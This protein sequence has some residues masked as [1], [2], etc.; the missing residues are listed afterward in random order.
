MSFLEIFRKREGLE[1]RIT[2]RIEESDF[3]KRLVDDER[4]KRRMMRTLRRFGGVSE[5]LGSGNS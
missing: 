4:F 5:N 1:E 3:H 2:R